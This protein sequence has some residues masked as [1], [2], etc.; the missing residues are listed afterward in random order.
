MPGL[1]DFEVLGA[2]SKLAEIHKSLNNA[3]KRRLQFL[4]IKSI[5]STI[6][7]FFI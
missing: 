5:L 6:A 4:S 7:Y 3:F 2:T 1:V